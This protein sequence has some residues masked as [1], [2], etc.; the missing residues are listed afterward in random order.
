MRILMITVCIPIKDKSKL[1]V[2]KMKLDIL[3]EYILLVSDA[4]GLANSR[5]ELMRQVKTEW[6]L[7]I[8][9]DIMITPGWW[10]KLRKYMSDPTV[11]AVNGLGLA[12]SKILKAIRLGLILVRGKSIQRGFTSNTLIRT[13]AVQGITLERVGRLEDME[14]QQKIIAN[15][16]KW[17]LCQRAVC[18]HLKPPITVWKEALGDFMRL[19]K[20]LGFVEAIRRI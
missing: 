11:G 3:G 9:D 16:Y 18:H 20:E 15:G 4:P 5:N 12:N 10:N 2:K 14:L 17:E 19:T 13:A 8:D 6:F 7:F 1:D